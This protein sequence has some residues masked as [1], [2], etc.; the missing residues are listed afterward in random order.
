MAQQFYNAKP[1]KTG[2]GC[3][4]SFDS[5]NRAVYASFVQQS[6]WNAQTKTGAFN[7]EKINLKLSVSEAG[8][9]I[10]AIDHLEAFS[11]FHDTSKGNY[12]D[13]YTTQISF[14]PFGPKDSEGGIALASLRFGVLRQQD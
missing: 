7:G 14:M 6:S 12:A 11:A 3:G 4:F 1:D 2:C 9:I 10:Y 5:K 8:A 13:K